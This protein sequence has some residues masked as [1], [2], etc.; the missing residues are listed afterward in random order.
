M[1]IAQKLTGSIREGDD[2]YR[3]EMIVQRAELRKLR[4]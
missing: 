2:A 1:R 4:S 3:R